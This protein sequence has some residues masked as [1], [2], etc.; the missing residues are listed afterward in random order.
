MDSVFHTNMGT[1]TRDL[2]GEALD[3]AI[4]L[5][6]HVQLLVIDEISIVGAAQFEI[7]CRRLEQVGKILWR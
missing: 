4:A 6:C 1:A 2:S 3:K 7:I 5:L